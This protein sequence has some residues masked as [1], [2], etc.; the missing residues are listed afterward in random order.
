MVKAG[1]AVRLDGPQ[2]AFGVLGREV[3]VDGLL[4]EQTSQLDDRRTEIFDLL[5]LLIGELELVPLELHIEQR[6]RVLDEH[7]RFAYYASGKCFRGMRFAVCRDDGSL[8]VRA[9]RERF[10][11][12]ERRIVHR[13]V[14]RAT[15]D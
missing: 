13:R 4:L 2:V 15:R 8:V 5:D 9:G 7:L 10:E 6:H 14:C 3:G 12:D 1:S 11:R